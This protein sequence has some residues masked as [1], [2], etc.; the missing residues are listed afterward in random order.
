MA[1]LPYPVAYRPSV[2]TGFQSS[3]S[4]AALSRAAVMNARTPL[5]AIMPTLARA[6]IVGFHPAV[7]AAIFALTTA[8]EI[9]DIAG[10]GDLENISALDPEADALSDALKELYPGWWPVRARVLNRPNAPV[11][12]PG[13]GWQ[14]CGFGPGCDTSLWGFLGFNYGGVACQAGLNCTPTG[15]VPNTFTPGDTAV[16]GLWGPAPFG[17]RYSRDQQW[18]TGASTG[19]LVFRAPNQGMVRP[20][21]TPMEIP[22]PEDFPL[23]AN[24]PWSLPIRQPGEVTIPSPWRHPARQPA[25]R[26]AAKPAVRPAV[27]IG[28]IRLPVVRVGPT[29]RLATA[30]RPKPLPPKPNT[31]EVR[32][33]PGGKA[34][35]GLHAIAH[36]VTESRDFVKALWQALPENNRGKSTK[37]P[38]MLTDLWN[39]WETIRDSEAYV[40][41]ALIQVIAE[42]LKDMFYGKAGTLFKEAYKQAVANGYPRAA[43]F[44]LGDRYRPSG[45]KLGSDVFES[46]ARQI[47][48]RVW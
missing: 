31:K 44:Q 41:E 30:A 38:A 5:A 14:N 29:V 22:V 34:S 46:I 25:T 18:N 20:M 15:A 9:S 39:N 42:N 16:R 12:F 47:V 43:G 35:T 11:V 24:N 37:V 17:N 13:N 19:P 7:S 48:D 23:F 36:L 27:R 21:Q 8:M 26:P 33:K 40:K 10:L 32:P 1:A 4:R 2:R 45:P 6:G 28:T 3:T